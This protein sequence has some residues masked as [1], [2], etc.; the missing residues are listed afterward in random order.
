MF[1]TLNSKIPV[2]FGKFDAAKVHRVLL[3]K[4]NRWIAILAV[5]IVP[6]FH[7]A[8]ALEITKIPSELKDSGFVSI[9]AG[10]QNREGINGLI[11]SELRHG[12]SERGAENG[13][14]RAEGVALVDAPKNG[15]ANA[16]GNQRR[17]WSKEAEVFWQGFWLLLGALIA[18]MMF[19]VDALLLTPNVHA[20]RRAANDG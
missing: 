20:H 12:V 9:E 13:S 15:A 1:D 2:C 4:R 10:L 19:L 6:S 5:V 18:P 17:Y 14:S 7:E 16:G 11:V 3:K 8:F